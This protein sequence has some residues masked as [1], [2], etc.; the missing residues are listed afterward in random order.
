MERIFVYGTLRKGMYNY[1][2][3]L[4]KENSFLQYAYVKG[5]LYTIQ[6]KK[7]PA[8]LL[9]GDSMIIGEIHEV[10][11][12]VLQRVDEMEEYFGDGCIDNEYNKVICDIYD[13]KQIVIDR[14]PV[15]VYNT[16]NVEKAKLL[17]EEIVSHDYVQYIKEKNNMG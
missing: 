17:G 11:Q 9:E 1:D 4:K 5:T 16:N 13:D 2:L 15:Y 3:Y 7:Y 8:L 10:N 12:D 6:S 14:L